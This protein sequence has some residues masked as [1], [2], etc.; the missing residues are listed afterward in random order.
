VRATDHAGILGEQSFGVALWNTSETGAWQFVDTVANAWTAGAPLGCKVYTYPSAES[1]K[2]YDEPPG[3]EFQALVRGRNGSQAHS[4]KFDCVQQEALRAQREA[5]RVERLTSR[6]ALPMELMLLKPLPLWKRT[7][8]VLAAS[9]GLVLLSPLQFVIAA[10]IKLTSPGPVFF[11]QLRDGLGGRPFTIYK[12]RTMR[13][14]AD[15]EKATLR[16]FSEQDGPAFKMKHDPRI[17]SIGRY[18]RKSC[19]DELPQLWN[20]LKGDMSLVGPRP[21]PC[22]ESR[23]CADWERRRLEVSPGL[24]CIWQVRGKSRVPFVEWMRMDIRYIK[25]RSFFYD[26]A[27]VLETVV[28]V[29]FHRA[30]H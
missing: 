16:Q 18:L 4:P 24:T 26:L 9:V 1:G 8:D 14:G 7:I 22:D 29:A 30:S 27:L 10:L 2:G 20:V 28:A 17:T 3:D 11:T 5:P 25:A 19:I 12:F 21:L 15:A 13:V 23:K 6:T